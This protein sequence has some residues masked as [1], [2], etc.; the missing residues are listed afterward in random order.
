MITLSNSATPRSV[1]H[2][3][4]CDGF[5]SSKDVKVSSFPMA[6][7]LITA[8]GSWPG[9][10]NHDGMDSAGGGKRLSMIVREHCCHS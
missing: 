6:R 10:M 5:S 3:L 7:S 8:D 1:S 2:E 9:L 4:N